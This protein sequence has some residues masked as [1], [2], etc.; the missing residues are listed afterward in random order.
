MRSKQVPTKACI[1]R[2]VSALLQSE[3]P[4]F[5]AP[6]LFVLGLPPHPFALSLM[7]LVAVSVL[8]LGSVKPLFNQYYDASDFADDPSF[9][10]FFANHVLRDAA[11]TFDVGAITKPKVSVRL[12]EKGSAPI[13]VRKIEDKIAPYFRLD[14]GFIIYTM[15]QGSWAARPP[16]EE[17]EH[18]VRAAEPEVLEVGT[19]G[20]DDE[21]ALVDEDGRPYE[22]PPKRRRS[23]PLPA[24]SDDDSEYSKS[25]GEADGGGGGWDSEEYDAFVPAAAGSEG[26]KGGSVDGGSDDGGSDDGAAPPSPASATLPFTPGDVC[27]TT[28]PR[29]RSVKVERLGNATD[30]FNADHVRISYVG[31]AKR[32]AHTRTRRTRYC[33]PVTVVLLLTCAA[34]SGVQP[35]RERA[36]AQEADLLCVGAA[37]AARAA[38]WLGARR[39]IVCRRLNVRRGRACCRARGRA[40]RRARGRAYRPDRRIRRAC[41]AAGA[42]RARASA[43]PA[44]GAART[45][46]RTSDGS[47]ADGGIEGLRRQAE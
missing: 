24:S 33:Y 23:K 11:E 4:C 9:S 7:S 41:H 35:A 30:F 44:A 37:R 16:L 6:I 10:S 14:I 32:C 5:A 39:L 42:C 3:C 34:S 29:A 45:C 31:P 27:K 46:A 1:S 25:D 38:L 28:S 36:G 40:C 12:R 2:L 20:D 19:S 17:A 8:E 26:A 13:D 47:A 15:K 21:E 18:A 43:R 22:P